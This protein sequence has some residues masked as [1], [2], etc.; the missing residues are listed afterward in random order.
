VDNVQPKKKS[1]KLK[2]HLKGRLKR[3]GRGPIF[4]CRVLRRVTVTT[5]WVA[6]EREWE[7]AKMQKRRNAEIAG[8]LCR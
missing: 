6:V 1:G 3:A 8:G 7:K 5:Q 4:W 2:C